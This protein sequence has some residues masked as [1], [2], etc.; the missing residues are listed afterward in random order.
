VGTFLFV[1]GRRRALRTLAAAGVV[2]GALA[3]LDG[4]G[5][6]WVE[7]ITHRFLPD[8]V[9]GRGAALDAY[10]SGRLGLWQRIAAYLSDNPLV[11]LFGVGFRALPQLAE[12]GT[13]LA[14]NDYLRLL[15]ETGL[16]GVGLTVALMAACLRGAWLCRSRG[17]AFSVPAGALLAGAWVM[18]ASFMF[19]G[20]ALTFWRSLPLL[21]LLQFE[22]LW[23]SLRDT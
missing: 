19:V 18:Q 9:A 5:V 1:A 20:D 12:A 8:P 13:R 21:F 6:S 23:A 22:L 17:S 11:L 4:L 16:C 3:A 2:V 14:D 15:I 10:L 7:T